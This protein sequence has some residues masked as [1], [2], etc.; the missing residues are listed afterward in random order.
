[1]SLERRLRTA[2]LTIGETVELAAFNAQRNPEFDV[3]D[4]VEVMAIEGNRVVISKLVT[5]RRAILVDREDLR[6][7]T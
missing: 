6:K 4:R 2:P 3:D 5:V 7:L 1:M